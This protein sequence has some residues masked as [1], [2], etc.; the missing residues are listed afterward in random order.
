MVNISEPT[1]TCLGPLCNGVR[2]PWSDFYRTSTGN[3][4]WVCK[5]CES[6]IAAE[7]QRRHRAE[8]PERVR[9]QARNG[10]H[11]RKADPEWLGARR[12]YQRA[13]MDR[14]RRA[15]GI[16]EGAKRGAMKGEGSSGG[17]WPAEQFAAWLRMVLDRDSVPI[18]TLAV[19]FALPER[20]LR[21]I[22]NGE[23]AMTEL[24]TIERALVH[25]GA[26]LEDVYPE[27]DGV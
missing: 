1:K 16:P 12:D 26:R 10:Y 24:S 27:M 7:R 18:A 22:V 11:R 15:R 17:L 13:A 9:A 6:H 3:P 25:E 23:T 5:L 14:Y 4:R 21:A 20:R 19:R 8:D 2:K